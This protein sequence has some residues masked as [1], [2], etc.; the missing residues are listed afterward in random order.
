[1]SEAGSA[2]IS[3][4]GEIIYSKSIGFSDVENKV[5]ATENSK[6]ELVQFPNRSRLF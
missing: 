3:K 5:K 1:M 4:N 2:A 6:S